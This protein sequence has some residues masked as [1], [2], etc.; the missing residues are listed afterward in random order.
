MNRALLLLAFLLSASRAGADELWLDARALVERSVTTGARL[1]QDGSAIE[2]ESGVLVEDD[3]PA[4]GYSYRPNEEKLSDRVWAKKELVL[5]DPR[6]HSATLLVGPGGSKITVNGKPVERSNSTKAGGYWEAIPLPP[7]SLKSG[8]NEI[9]LHGGGRVWIARAEDFASG[10]VARPRHPGRSA[11]S[12]DGGKTWE[13]DRLGPDGG[14]HGEYY[15]RLF[16]DRFV[17]TGSLTMPVLDAANLSGRSVGPPLAAVGPIRIKLDAETSATGRI[18]IRVRFGTTPIPDEKKW[19]DWKPLGEE[20]TIAEPTGRYFQVSIGFATSDPLRTPRLKG[21]TISARPEK[22]PDEW[23]AQLKVMEFQNEEIV[24]SSIPFAYEPFDHPKLRQLREQ[25]KLDA[26]VKGAPSELELAERL[27]RW[28]AGRW[29][30][31]HLKDSYPAWDA[32]GILKPHRDGTPVGGFCQQ[33]NLVFLQA[34]ESFGIPGR[35][36]SIGPGDHGGKIRG[37]GHE[38]VELWSNQ[39]KKWFYID[40]NMAW[41]AVDAKSG[42]PLSLRELR[43]RQLRRLKDKDYP[44]IRIVHLNKDGKRWTGLTEWPPFLELRMIPRSNFLEK[45]E[46]LPLNQGMRGWFWTGHH[47]WSDAEYSASRLYGHRVTS[48]HNWDWTLNQAH[49]SLEATDVP[50]EVRVHLDTVTPGFETFVA[51]M[52]DQPAQPVASGFVWSF[53]K[54]RNLLEVRPRNIAGRDGITSHVMLEYR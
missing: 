4:A 39:F 29:E 33:H 24:R 21:V 28:S 13:Q 52:N 1:T 26:V 34:C 18:E 47:I 50:G 30:R 14:I 45:R 15:I 40:G 7:E 36:V 35:A 53:R 42:I 31:G 2:L 9:I 49:I 19:S 23:T 51:K 41:Y 22:S 25:Y 48:P 38:V 11:R 20:G 46:P 54:G 8:T 43:E 6:A 3:G 27:A 5:S 17:E 10:S 44:P 12:R 32:L 16:L 37:G